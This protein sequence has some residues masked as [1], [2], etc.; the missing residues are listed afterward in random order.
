MGLIYGLIYFVLRV[1]IHKI[2]TIKEYIMERIINYFLEGSY[3]RLLRILSP[4][5]CITIYYI[6]KKQKETNCLI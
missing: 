1:A 6:I 4:I 5:I 2:T 3:Y